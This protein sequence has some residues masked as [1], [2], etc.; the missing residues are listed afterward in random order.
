MNV[1]LAKEF[2]YRELDGKSQLDARLGMYTVPFTAVGGVVIYLVRSA[3]IGS[4]FLYLVGLSAAV[5]SLVIYF[6]ALIWLIRATIGFTYK[7]VPYP[8]DLKAHWDELSTYHWK[9]PSAKGSA[10]Q[11]FNE[12]LI[13]L[14]CRD[15]TINAKNN[16]RRAARYYTVG[17]LLLWVIVFGAISGL[18]QVIPYIVKILQQKGP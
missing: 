6:V 12:D 14:C 16:T 10:P 7:R 15:A 5:A 17:V 4:G 1:D 13:E 11:E 18:I 9:Y 2:Y 3:W 8:Q